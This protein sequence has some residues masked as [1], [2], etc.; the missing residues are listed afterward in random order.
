LH[1]EDDPD[2]RRI[3]SD[4]LRGT[5]EIVE[6]SNLREARSALARDGF[7]LI[8][9]DIGL[10]DGSGVEIL[11]DMKAKNLAIPILVF[12]ADEFDEK[13]SDLVA[14]ALVKSRTS[15]DELVRM[16]KEL[17]RQSRAIH[18]RTRS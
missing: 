16:I 10:P 12:S 15:N 9:L 11:S 7:S 3:L 6:A 4:L 2:V 5:A 14:S 17:L 13:T 18:V 1:I 8:I